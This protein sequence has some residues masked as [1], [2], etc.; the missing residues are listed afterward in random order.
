MSGKIILWEE[1]YVIILSL[2]KKIE[3]L[4]QIHNLYMLYK[5]Q[6]KSILLLNIMCFFFNKL[7]FFE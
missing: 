7:P 6:K 5:S 3:N 1:Q 4:I 2:G